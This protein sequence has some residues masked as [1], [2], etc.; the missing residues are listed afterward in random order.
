MGL[1]QTMNEFTGL[2]YTTQTRELNYIT[3][4]ESDYIRVRVQEKVALLFLDKNF[5]IW[6]EML[7]RLV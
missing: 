6:C 3:A 5:L 2:L 1:S 4:A 7:V